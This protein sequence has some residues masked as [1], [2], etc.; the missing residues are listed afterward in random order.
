MG[1]G[2]AR[3]RARQREYIAK[4]APPQ[5]IMGQA[6]LRANT[7][8][9]PRT[10]GLAEALGLA[11]AGQRPPGSG[12]YDMDPM[13]RDSR[14][15]V[16]FGPSNPLAPAPIDPHRPD[17]GRPEPRITEYPVSFNLPNG[18][19]PVMSWSTLRGAAQTV[20]IIRRCIEVRKEQLDE[21]EWSIGIDDKIVESLYASRTRDSRAD[22]AEEMR[23]RF[24]PE[25]ERLTE[26]WCNP[27]PNNRMGWG[28]WVRALMEERLVL[29]ATAIYPR[30]TYG[31]DILDFEII[32]GSTIKPLISF[33]GT[34]PEAPYPAYQQILY[35]FPRGEFTAPA[36]YEQD[37]Q[38]GALVEHMQP[39]MLADQM[40]Y[41]VHNSRVQ[42]PYG[43]S[44][45]EQ[46]LLSASIYLKR[47][48]WMISEYDDGST[49]QMWLV[50]SAQD[51]TMVS[52]M[53]ATERRQWEATV[54]AELVGN[55][56]GR[57]RIKITPP[58]F[59]PIAM[60]SVDERY[61]PDYD[62]FLIK[63]LSM[64]FGVTSTGLGFS[65]SKGLGNSGLHEGQERVQDGATVGPDKKMISGIVNQLMHRWQ[66]APKELKHSY[67][68][69]E[70]ED[71]AAQDGV[72]NAQRARGTITLNE[73]RRAAGLAPADFP[74]ADML[75]VQAG[76]AGWV[77]LEGIV[78]RME[79]QQA[80]EQALVDAQAAP[81][82]G[83]EVAE[84]DA[85]KALELAEYRRWRRKRGDREPSRPFLCKAL[86]P[87]DFADGVP[88][89]VDFE[90]WVWVPDDVSMDDVIN[91]GDGWR[92]QLRDRKGRWMKMG[93][94]GPALPGKQVLAGLKEQAEAGRT[95]RAAREAAQSAGRAQH[96]SSTMGGMTS[97]KPMSQQ[98]AGKAGETRVT[99]ALKRGTTNSVEVKHDGKPQYTAYAEDGAAM[100]AIL[101]REIDSL[102]PKTSA[103]PVAA[104]P[105]EPKAAKLTPAARARLGDMAQTGTSYVGGGKLTGEHAELER[106]GYGERDGNW[107]NITDAGRAAAPEIPRGDGPD[108]TATKRELSALARKDSGLLR[109]AKEANAARDAAS[110]DPVAAARAELK[111][112]EDAHAKTWGKGPKAAQDAA[113][114]VALAQQR[115]TEAERKAKQAPAAPSAPV[116]AEDAVRGGHAALS[117]EGAPV[118]LRD[119]R[120]HMAQQGVADR[121]EQDR[122]LTDMAIRQDVVALPEENQRAL[123][124]ADRAAAL[125]LGGEDKHLIHMDQPRPS[126]LQQ[127]DR[128][129]ALYAKAREELAKVPGVKQGVA[130]RQQRTTR[131]G[132]PVDPDGPVIVRPE[133]RDG[134]HAIPADPFSSTSMDPLASAQQAAGGTHGRIAGHEVKAGTRLMYRD[135]HV[136]EALENP[137][138]A[139]KDSQG[140]EGVVF[141]VR[142]E[143]GVG[144]GT[145][146]INHGDTVALAAPKAS[147]VP[148]RRGAAA[149]VADATPRVEHSATPTAR[150]LTLPDGIT[151]AQ[152]ERLE[153]VGRKL[154]ERHAA[155]FADHEVRSAKRIEDARR[156][157]AENPD[158]VIGQR[159]KDM[160]A[161]EEAVARAP[162]GDAAVQ[163]TKAARELV[164]EADKRGYAV[165][166]SHQ[167]DSTGHPFFEVQVL[168]PARNQ[169]VKM[170]WHTR[171]TKGDTYAAFSGSDHRGRP[172]TAKAISEWMDAPEREAAAAALVQSRPAL[173]T[174]PAVKMDTADIQPGDYRWND[175]MKRWEQIG[176]ISD[177]RDAVGSRTIYGMDRETRLGA[178]PR[179]SKTWVVRGEK[180]TAPPPPE[181]LKALQR[182]P[183]EKVKRGDLYIVEH[184]DSAYYGGNSGPRN[185]RKTYEVHE[186]TSVTRDGKPTKLRKLGHSYET[187]LDQF[188]RLGREYGRSSILPGDKINMAELEA[189]LKAR[190][191]PNSTTP[192]DH[193]NMGE[194]SAVLFGRTKP[195][196]WQQ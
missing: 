73:D 162:R 46:A 103:D 152:R 190:T 184:T 113:Y 189:D 7:S 26:F 20:D 92:H 59:Q 99:V 178:L 82:D 188:G 123:T 111:A 75:M 5:G 29:D 101:Q 168:D 80:N 21:L 173:A 104:A 38:T 136:V 30:T 94:H 64:P 124:D 8:A 172:A 169:G 121:A 44:E 18:E 147:K 122:V 130:R 174:S 158:G 160:V 33:R 88:R 138:R 192:R 47:R 61:K 107:L 142:R 164:A 194:L 55:T 72:R 126:V 42:T 2:R 156:F 3:A 43:Y 89:D 49:P 19:R 66:K 48:G 60:S 31:G 185:P 57:H 166:V 11:V 65:E 76:P 79:Q 186:V 193:E 22:I 110:A 105:A 100:D 129:A 85:A 69:V 96:S 51:Q 144:E 14:D 196:A 87:D 45:T 115:L 77:P 9:A 1:K 161:R 67:V 135:Q 62:M 177:Q 50:P 181:A 154:D 90:S 84:E 131:I 109:Q 119:L 134:G 145:M 93:T 78:E 118:K 133:G 13:L 175:G 4:A 183:E 150:G 24:L 141:R 139:A 37:P 120:E 163:A 23:Q 71:T 91:K 140:R 112:A 68:E 36:T 149:V 114:Q 167:E 25:I 148:Q 34:Q 6:L 53:S 127:M 143:D 74:E 70:Q 95:A 63:I 132:D 28:Q 56:G 108:F 17:T 97:P 10:F 146:R 16:P 83:E 40:F 52:K 170:T 35:G 191:Y 195:E 39:G 182:G 54:N 116:N 151:G 159:A 41:Y 15:L 81:V 187:K 27:W 179:D 165:M 117:R 137:R 176:M 157:A 153:E 180:P 106:A 86:E 155:L 32:D 102:S 171:K 128:D 58:G 125:R 12:M 98:R